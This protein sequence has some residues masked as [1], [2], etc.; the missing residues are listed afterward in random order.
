MNFLDK[1]SLDNHVILVHRKL[2]QKLITLEDF[3]NLYNAITQTSL[4]SGDSF[5]EFYSSRNSK[6]NFLNKFGKDYLGTKLD[7]QESKVSALYA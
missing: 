1:F 2:V 3:I 5:F 4:I 7:R 6:C